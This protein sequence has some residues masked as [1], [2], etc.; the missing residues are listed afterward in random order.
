MLNFVWLQLY[1][2]YLL[3]TEHKLIL[4]CKLQTHPKQIQSA[5]S[6]L[7]STQLGIKA[8]YFIFQRHIL[9]NRM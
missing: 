8:Y 4:C 5:F 2:L 1:I 9:K 6:F 7:L 3:R